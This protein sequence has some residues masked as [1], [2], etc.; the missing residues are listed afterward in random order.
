MKKKSNT[1]FITQTA[2]IAAI[3][4]VLTYISSVFGLA[5]G[6]IQCRLSEALCVLPAFT[7]A[8][9]PGLFVGCILA[10]F[11]CG[12]MFLDI[13]FGSLATLL[14]AVGTY[15]LSS[16]RFNACLFPLP[17][18]VS[19]SLI[20]PIVLKYAYALDKSALYFFVTVG[21]GELISCEVLGMLLYYSLKKNEKN[22]FR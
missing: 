8:A 13:L 2:I 22:L 16:Y 9:I 4:V 15:Y 7:P 17:A 3:Y 21:I 14:G 5:S 11:L 18:I 12:S 1:R 19:N 10:N 20:I 6:A